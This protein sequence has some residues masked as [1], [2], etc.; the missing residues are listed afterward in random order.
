MTRIYIVRHG[1]SELNA[2]K[3][4]FYKDW[5]DKGINGD[6]LDCVFDCPWQEEDIPLTLKGWDQA[7]QTG[8]YLAD[9]GITI[10]VVSP[11]M[12]T[13]QTLEAIL[14]TWRTRPRII[15]DP[16]IREINVGARHGLTNAAFEARYPGELARKRLDK[17]NWRPPNGESYADLHPRIVPAAQDVLQLAQSANVLVV[18]HGTSTR[19]LRQ[20]FENQTPAEV[21]ALPKADEPINCGVTTYELVSGAPQLLSY[22]VRHYLHA[23]SRV[24]N[25]VNAPRVVAGMVVLE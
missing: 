13:L 2:M 15:V 25:A 5:Q 19:I 14:S 3:E 9:K 18:T 24:Q 21:I 16:R 17:Y 12:R 10:A 8:A 1:E 23:E 22:N 20:V 11:F 7:A 4:R 6:N